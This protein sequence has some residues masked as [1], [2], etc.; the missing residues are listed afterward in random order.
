MEQFV[1][2]ACG[3]VVNVEAILYPYRLEVRAERAIGSHRD[4]DVAAIKH[5][6]IPLLRNRRR[7]LDELE[8]VVL[9]RVDSLKV[10]HQNA[11]VVL[12]WLHAS[13]VQQDGLQVDAQFCT[14]LQNLTHNTNSFRECPRSHTW[15][16]SAQ[17]GSETGLRTT[18]DHFPRCLVVQR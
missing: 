12:A 13:I 1:S 2:Y 8:V 10:F 16:P 14:F 15:G 18:L 7:V 4:G 11:H 5:S 17:L 6:R 9:P 3:I